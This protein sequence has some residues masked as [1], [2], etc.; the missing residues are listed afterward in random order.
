VL[1]KISFLK[2]N[3]NTIKDYYKVMAQNYKDKDLKQNDYLEQIGSNSSNALTP[4]MWA[5]LNRPYADRY[6]KFDEWHAKQ[7][8]KQEG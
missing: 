5:F 6:L 1:L 2:S 4:E 7:S 3:R 8:D